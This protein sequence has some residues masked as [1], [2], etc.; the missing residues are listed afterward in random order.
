MENMKTGEEEEEGEVDFGRTLKEMMGIGRMD[1]GEQRNA[2]NA[3]VK[4]IYQRTVLSEMGV[5]ITKFL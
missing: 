2:S 3:K 4:G 5:K 1:Q